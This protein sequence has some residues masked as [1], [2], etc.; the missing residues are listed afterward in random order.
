M[1][2]PN[3]IETS[4]YRDEGFSDEGEAVSLD[5]EKEDV[6]R[7][8]GK[9]VENGSSFW[10]KRLSLDSVRKRNEKRWM[11]KNFEVSGAAGLYDYQTHYRDNRIFLSVETLVS[12]VV[13]KIPEPV[14][15]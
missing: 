7:I 11:N 9:R 3:L 1:P 12:Q 10:N 15:T 2:S 4:G 8:I 5:L 6:L 13:A 14:V